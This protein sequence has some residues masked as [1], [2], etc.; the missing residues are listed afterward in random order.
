MSIKNFVANNFTLYPNKTLTK[1]F[2]IYNILQFK[3]S[4]INGEIDFGESYP[5]FVNINSDIEIN[6]SE[7]IIIKAKFVGKYDESIR[8]FNTTIIF[9]DV[10]K[11]N[12]FFN[13]EKLI[14][15]FN[16]DNSEVYDRIFDEIKIV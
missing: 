7:D 5:R 10:S 16:T 12:K 4:N 6:T 14:E 2:N 1:F 11:I 8:S 15:F 9:N 3:F 13:A